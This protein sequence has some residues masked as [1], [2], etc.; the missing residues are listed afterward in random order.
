[1]FLGWCFLPIWKQSEDQNESGQKKSADSNQLYKATQI[2]LFQSM[3]KCKSINKG[4]LK[5]VGESNVV[6]IN[7]PVE[8]RNFDTEVFQ[9]TFLLLHF[10]NYLG[11]LRSVN[12]HKHDRLSKSY[13]MLQL[14]EP[15]LGIAFISQ[16]GW[17]GIKFIQQHQKFCQKENIEENKISFE[18][19]SDDK[20]RIVREYWRDDNSSYVLNHRTLVEN[21]NEYP[22]QLDKLKLHLGS[23][24]PNS[25]TL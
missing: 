14:G 18:W 8:E 2:L 5:V 10:T 16:N 20:I 13:E 24:F 9:M 25:Q 7:E 6:T 3:I 22:V 11:G 23:A 15:L 4:K 12:L 1:M 17:I 21:L 19:I